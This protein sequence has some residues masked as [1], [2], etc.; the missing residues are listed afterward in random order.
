MNE[1][2]SYVKCMGLTGNFS[3]ALNICLKVVV[4]R[5]WWLEYLSLNDCFRGQE[6][7]HHITS[8]WLLGKC[9]EMLAKQ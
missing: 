3:L 2:L 4:G 6:N 8:V 9:W 7:I 5:R 1:I